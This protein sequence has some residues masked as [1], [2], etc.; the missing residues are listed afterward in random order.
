MNRTLVVAV[1]VVLRAKAA[2]AQFV[3]QGEPGGPIAGNSAADTPSSLFGLPPPMAPP[4]A[5]RRKVFVGL[6]TT[7][8]DSGEQ[9]SLSP[10]VNVVVEPG[11]PRSGEQAVYQA[12]VYAPVVAGPMLDPG[13]PGGLPGPSGPT[14][15]PGSAA[16]PIPFGVEFLPS[17]TVGPPESSSPIFDEVIAGARRPQRGGLRSRLRGL[18]MEPGV[19]RERAVHAPFEL[20]S[21]QPLGNIRFRFASIN[22]TPFPDRAEYLWGRTAG[23]RGPAVVEPN[24]DYQELRTQLELGSPKFST[25]TEFPLR[26]TNP[27]VNRNHAGFGDMRLTVK[28]VII[29]GEKLQITQHFRSYFPTGSGSMGLG[30]GHIS[31][32]PGALGRYKW[33]DTTYFHGELKYFFPIGGDPTF[34][35]QVLQYGLGVSHVLVDR[36]N[37]ALLSTWEL[38]AA[39]VANGQKTNPNGTIADAEGEHLISMASGL[40]F[41]RDCGGDMGL[42][43]WGISGSVPVSSPRFFDGMLKLD[44]RWSY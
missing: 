38:P 35:G 26:W 44:F 4:P 6:P 19:G 9:L 36:D 25:A 8:P 11:V 2:E 33:S 28:T 42:F 5:Q 32:E 18:N 15:P 23:G 14:G 43:E 34:S 39:Y 10:N 12:G 29:D 24:L 27:D 3:F 31:L 41:V 20:D 22:N 13:P 17:Q 16:E 40:R 1:L 30:T 7:A 21:S 37:F